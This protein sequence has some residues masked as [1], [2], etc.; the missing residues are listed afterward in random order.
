MAGRSSSAF[1]TTSWT[2]VQAAASESGKDSDRA[3]AEL[4]RAYWQPVYAFIRRCGHDRDSAQDLSQEFF[5]LLI[6][7]NYLLD[8]DQSRGK[9]RT[10]LLAAVKH[11]LANEWDR[12]R[13]QKRGGDRELISIDVVEA[14]RWYAPIALEATTPESVFEHRWA[15]SLLETVALKLRAE[16]TAAGRAA[17]FETLWVFLHRDGTSARYAEVAEQLGMSDGALRMAV[18][19]MRR[20]YRKLLR[21]EVTETV[22]TPEQA[23]DEIRFLLATLS[24]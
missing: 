16:F 8:A 3:L 9:F 21:A 13:A 18:H 4:C 2:L 23:D 14:E 22:S 11:F 1:H 24:G 7:K 19:R 10:F 12:A 15:L 17:E 20:R 5:A 6:E